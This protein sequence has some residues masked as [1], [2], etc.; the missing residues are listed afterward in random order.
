[1]IGQIFE[2]KNGRF[3]IDTKELAAGDTL[4]VLIVD[5]RDGQARWIQITVEQNND[6]YYLLGL[7]GYSP[8]GLFGRL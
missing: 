3:Q 4:E 5:G 6:G 7:F 1:M 8:I 2:N